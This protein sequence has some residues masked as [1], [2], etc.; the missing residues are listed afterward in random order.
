MASEP[1]EPEPTPTSEPAAEAGSR[2]RSAAPLARVPDWLTRFGTAA[3]LTLGILAL[4]VVAYLGLAQLSALVVPLVISLVIGMIFHPAVDRLAQMG[5]PR[6]V[7]SALVMLGLALAVALA[8]WLSVRGVLDQSNLILEQAQNGWQVVQNWLAQQGLSVENLRSY[9]ENISGS[10]ASGGAAGLVQAGFSGFAAFL[11]GL[12]IAVFLLYYLLKD[13]HQVRE[14]LAGHVGLPHDLGSGLIEDATTAIRRYFYGLAVTALPVSV[15]IGLAM[16]LLGLP[17]AFTVGVVTFITSFIPY[18]GAI[19]SGAFT[20]LVALGA[21]GVTDA[22]IMLVVVI[23]AQNVI[24]TLLLT[25]ITSDQLALH[26]IVN[27]GSTI[28]GATLAGFV[29]ATL[30]AP[31]VAMLVAARRRVLD[32]YSDQPDPPDPSGSPNARADAPS[33]AAG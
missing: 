32:Y 33:P 14:W 22:V 10:G 31:I 29:G 27:L 1:A 2:G 19:L 30:S 20:V 15:I 11:I 9:W 21:G 25:K 17:L 24:Q 12:F 28:V 5:V 16:Y 4:L 8:V 23:V 18:L 7:G 13:W 26:P 6:M 3:W